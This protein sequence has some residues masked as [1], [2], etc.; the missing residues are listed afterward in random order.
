MSHRWNML[1]TASGF[2]SVL[3]SSDKSKL[4]DR[5]P[6]N[7][8]QVLRDATWTGRQVWEELDDITAPISMT[9]LA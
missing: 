3:I 6:R 7:T 4:E 5:N 8:D 1:S 9:K 2:I